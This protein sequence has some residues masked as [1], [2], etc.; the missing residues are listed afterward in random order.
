MKI[1]VLEDICLNYIMK[2]IEPVKSDLFNADDSKQ[3]NQTDKVP[4]K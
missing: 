1:K 2:S 3:R 4:G